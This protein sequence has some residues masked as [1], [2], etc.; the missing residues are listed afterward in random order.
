MDCKSGSRSVDVNRGR[1]GKG[2]GGS[3]VWHCWTG[4]IWKQRQKENDDRIT[5]KNKYGNSFYGYL[6]TMSDGLVTVRIKD[7]AL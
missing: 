5:V 6:F 4:L 7:D 2:D 1:A 3:E